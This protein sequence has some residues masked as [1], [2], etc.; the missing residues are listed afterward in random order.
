MH[1]RIGPLTEIVHLNTRLFGNCLDGITPV[2]V[3]Q[4]EFLE[5]TGD[6]HLRHQI[7]RPAD[8]VSGAPSLVDERPGHVL[9]GV[10]FA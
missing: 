8:R 5:W 6:N 9:N 3:G 1:R 2:M 4:F 7:H 10:E